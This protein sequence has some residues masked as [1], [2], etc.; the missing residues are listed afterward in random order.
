V[1]T[2]LTYWIALEPKPTPDTKE[3]EI[4]KNAKN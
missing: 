2:P 1:N 4:K 3:S